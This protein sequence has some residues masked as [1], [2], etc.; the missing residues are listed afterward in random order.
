MKLKATPVCLEVTASVG[1]ETRAGDLG[2][3]SHFGTLSYALNDHFFPLVSTL[4]EGSSIVKVLPSW[5]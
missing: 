2:S 1:P 3:Y 5:H 4:L